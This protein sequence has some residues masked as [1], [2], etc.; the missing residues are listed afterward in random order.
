MTLIIT[1]IALVIERFFDWGHIRQWQ[2]FTRYQVKLSAQLIK[3]PPYLALAVCV[4][5]FVI[6]IALLN[7]LLFGWLFGV[8]KLI[9]GIFIL[10]YCFGPANLWAEIYYCLTA[11]N[12]DPKEAA[13]S[14]QEKF[15]IGSFANAAD[16]H[17]AL[18]KAIFVQANRR[19]FAVLFWFVI[20]G[21]AGAVLYRLI[22]LCGERDAPLLLADRAAKIQTMLDWLPARV[23]TFMFA[24]GGHFT[25]VF[26][27]WR[28]RALAGPQD[29]NAL[30]GECGI[31]ALD[32]AS[33]ENFP[34]DQTP[35]K[36]SVALLDRALV[37]TLVL[38]AMVVLII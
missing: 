38:L 29:N 19:V 2:W 16:F 23:L 18:T 36:E 7:Y 14:I 31:A 10:V 4:L 20:L 21:P 11:L 8:L 6:F 27:C 37:L 13:Q 12:D 5:P 25:R 26:S 30:L 28:R 22:A 3:W 34:E 35:E 1:L 17:Q 15:H 32:I 24:L 9:F 33:A